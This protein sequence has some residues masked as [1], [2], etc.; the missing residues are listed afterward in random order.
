MIIPNKSLITEN[1]INWTLNNAITRLVLSVGVAYGSDVDK[2]RTLLIG[3]VEDHPDVL[4]EPPPS[5]FFMN[6]GD[7]SLDFELRIFVANPNKRLPVTHDINTAI[8]SVLSRNGIDIPF[9]QRTLHIV[10]ED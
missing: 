8:N 10:S 2:V 4:K 1:V 7:S 5:V 9:P 3:V 6:H